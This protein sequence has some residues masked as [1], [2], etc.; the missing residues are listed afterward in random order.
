[1]PTIVAIANQK[2]GCGKTTTTMH[3][4]GGL[5]SIGY[6]VKVVDTDP[7]ATAYMWDAKDSLTFE[8]QAVPEGA[9]KKELTKIATENHTDIVLVDCPPGLSGATRIALMASNA[10]IV[11][12]RVGKGDY[13]ATLPFLDL[14]KQALDANPQLK[15][16]AFIN[17]RANSAIDKQARDFAVKTFAEFANVTVLKTEVPNLALVQKTHFLGTT[18]FDFKGARNTKALHTYNHLIKEILECLSNQ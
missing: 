3:L 16:M 6:K 14:M 18:M 1:M 2:G 13:E 15:V 12:I 5:S 9:L 4:A 17:A 10:A 7:Q 11:P 8:V